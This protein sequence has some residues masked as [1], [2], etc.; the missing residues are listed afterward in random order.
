VAADV[1]GGGGAAEREGRTWSSS[2]RQVEPQLPP[3][4]SGYWQRSPSLRRTSRSVAAGRSSAASEPDRPQSLALPG[5]VTPGLRTCAPRASAHRHHS[6][7]AA[8]GRP[9]PCDLPTW[10]HEGEAHRSA[11]SRLLPRGREGI[12]VPG[13][14]G[15]QGSG[16]HLRTWRRLHGLELHGIRPL[17][18][19]QPHPPGAPAGLDARREPFTVRAPRRRR[20]VAARPQERDASAIP[21]LAGAASA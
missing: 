8:W 10:A 6:E 7:P 1:G 21:Y 14:R 11:P 4:S 9:C 17:P 18:V 16:L 5:L 19:Q 12:G 3:P 15:H 13:L 2:T 20:E